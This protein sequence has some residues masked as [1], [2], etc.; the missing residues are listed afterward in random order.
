MSVDTLRRILDRVDS[1]SGKP[2]IEFYRPSPGRFLLAE[3]SVLAFKEARAAPEFW[4]LSQAGYAE[5]L[6]GVLAPLPKAL[7][8]EKKTKGR[9]SIKVKGRCKTRA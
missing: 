4:R 9:V 3:A 6:T 7:F 1:A 2:L 8:R 5:P